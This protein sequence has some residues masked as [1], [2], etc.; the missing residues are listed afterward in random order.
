MVKSMDDVPLKDRK[1]DVNGPYNV[2][3]E[4]R[5]ADA[6]MGEVPSPFD[7]PLYCAKWEN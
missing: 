7:P 1:F 2:Q 5:S 4:R 3:K 6:R